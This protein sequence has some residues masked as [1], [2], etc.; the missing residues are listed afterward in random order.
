MCFNHATVYPESS[1]EKETG[2]TWKENEREREIER[3][4]ECEAG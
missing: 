3:E 4:A 2:K 1:R